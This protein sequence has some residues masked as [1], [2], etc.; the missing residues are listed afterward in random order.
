MKMLA[1]RIAIGAMCAVAVFVSD[2]RASS[3][4]ITGTPFGTDGV[5]AFSG[6]GSSVN[7]H[8]VVG[9]GP[10]GISDPYG[11]AGWRTQG[12]TTSS[13]VF[14]NLPY[15]AVDWYF[16]G[17]ESGHNN[18]FV[19][20]SLGFTEH[21]EN[22]RLERGNDPGPLFLGTTT[23]SGSGSPIPFS[24]IDLHYGSG[25][26]NGAN[27]KPGAFIASLMFAYVEPEYSKK[28]ALKGWRLTRKSTDWFAFGFD[29]QGSRND[30]H[31]DYVGIGHLRA[32]TPIP[33]ALP[34]MGT[35]VGGYLLARWRRHCTRR[36]AVATS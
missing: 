29:D 26:S 32:A 19:S 34:L 9:Y 33:G 4:T 30:D 28:G 23:G 27:H 20:T 5:G 25:V 6:Y 15:F 16:N 21:N 2:A 7:K 14:S 13:A 1:G 17:A 36:L 24:L 31:D 18:R 22:N 11:G 10:S 3:V 35:V 12:T 8:N